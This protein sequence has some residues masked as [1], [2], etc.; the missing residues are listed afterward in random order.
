ML[1]TIKLLQLVQFCSPWSQFPTQ[2]TIHELS[3]FSCCNDPYSTAPIALSLIA[4]ILVI[5]TIFG[6]GIRW[7][8]LQNDIE[9]LR[10]MQKGDKSSPA[11]AAQTSRLPAPA[12]VSYT[13]WGR[14]TCP[15]DSTLIYAG[16]DARKFY[17]Y[18]NK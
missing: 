9:E 8:Q 11:A 16:M 5:G 4:L 7:S 13:R 14:K 10:A 18:V 2:T 3:Y 1:C 15:G 12:Y 6:V 17:I